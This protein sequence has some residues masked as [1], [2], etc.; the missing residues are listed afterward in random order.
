MNNKESKNVSDFKEEFDVFEEHDVQLT[1]ELSR[2]YALTKLTGGEKSQ[3]LKLQDVAVDRSEDYKSSVVQ[4]KDFVSEKIGYEP[5]PIGRVEYSDI[6]SA[7]VTRLIH[8][9]D[10]LMYKD[11]LDNEGKEYPA[12]MEMR[13]GVT[14][15]ME[16]YVVALD[17]MIEKSNELEAAHNGV[18][19]VFR[20]LQEALER[21][22]TEQKKAEIER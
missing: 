6:E 2:F 18:D 12:L 5:H 10:A 11:I 4:L 1:A 15:S 16:N 17:K 19:T 3:L 13:D 21:S 7:T 20:G 22:G 9:L 8:S 14:I